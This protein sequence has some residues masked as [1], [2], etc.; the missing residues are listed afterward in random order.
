M[1][2]A[3]AETQTMHSAPAANAEAPAVL[4]IL[5]SLAT[6][7]V[8][9]GT[10]DI[11]AALIAAGWRAIVV[12]AGGPMA[13]E[14]ERVGGTHITLPVD[15]KN[16]LIMRKNIGSIAAVIRSHNVVI[17]HARS[18][19]PAWSAR[20]AAQRCGVPFMT[21]FHGTYNYG[22]PAKKAYNAIM[23]KGERIIA[24]SEFIGRHIEE[25]YD[26][27][28]EKLRV[29]PR[30][31]DIENFNP[32]AVSAE[33]MIQLSQAWRLPDGAPVI[34]LP[35]RLTRWKGQSVLI[36]AARRLD[37]DNVRV[38]LVGDDQGRTT[39]RDE[40]EA[41]IRRIGAEGIIHLTGPCRDMPA[42]YMLADVVISASTD[43]EA[44]GRIAAEAH[45]MGRP[46]IATDHGAA[47]ETVLAG[48]TGWL[49]PPGE[50]D[51]LTQALRRALSMT[52]EERET[53]AKC[54]ISHVR[55]NFTKLQMCA[56]TLAVYEELLPRP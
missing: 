19:A 22:H 29:I 37:R 26:V 38:L 42:A 43:P 3:E 51:A 24:I 49:T 36:E 16:P 14:I 55:N 48:K 32:N 7:G 54:A 47:R 41:Q 46:V 18:R 5:P 1:T 25:N 45:A 2:P 11:A 31:V 4:Q 44:F 56:S 34:M 17:V 23:T 27:A 33:R 52:S 13:Y 35:G 20:S 9:R 30:G 15:R 10:V 50:A 40:L 12:S 21:T 53:V 39:Y 28:R 6:G 8:E